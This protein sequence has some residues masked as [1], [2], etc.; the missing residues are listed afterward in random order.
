MIKIINFYSVFQ[1]K[2]GGV[3][4]FSENLLSILKKQDFKI[5]SYNYSASNR[6]EILLRTII[7]FVR[8][9]LNSNRI[10]SVSS[11][12]H[13]LISLSGIF[14][15]NTIII[16]HNSSW[17]KN[18]FFKKLVYLLSFSEKFMFIC[19]NNDVH[20]A[21]LNSKINSKYIPGY[22]FSNKKRNLSVKTEL[23][24]IAFTIWKLEKR[25]LSEI[26]GF[27]ILK[28][29]ISEINDTN[30]I[31]RFYIGE[32][33]DD[34][35]IND[36]NNLTR[37]T[38][39]KIGQNYIEN[40]DDV[41]LLL[42]TNQVDGYGLVLAESIDMGIYTIATNVCK[43]P[44]GTFV[45]DENDLK[46][47]TNHIKKIFLSFPKMNIKSYNNCNSKIYLKTINKFFTK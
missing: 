42:R 14:K 29:I 47:A 24:I 12:R 11:T 22:F 23:P 4:T 6:I 33:I 36:L 2:I 15:G 1:P 25:L 10:I 45:F 44:H 8:S 13:L 39:I 41:F 18:L 31:L 38:E 37:N 19:V 46:S 32:V 40:S 20:N 3:S 5:F 16:L 7:L 9:I 17:F 43:R 27:E 21:L 34:F 28:K 30:F 35:L 26:Y